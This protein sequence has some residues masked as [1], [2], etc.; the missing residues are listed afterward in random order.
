[1]VAFPPRFLHCRNCLRYCREFIYQWM[2]FSQERS[3][4][5][6]ARFH[7]E[8]AH[9]SLGSFR[10]QPSREHSPK[11][12]AGVCGH[13]KERR[14]LMEAAGNTEGSPSLFGLNMAYS[15]PLANG[16]KASVER[17]AVYGGQ[18]QGSRMK[19]EQR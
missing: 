6:L 2:L 3:M 1:M 7:V 16:L 10:H 12:I 17:K 11:N 18:G 19:L 13:E 8:A 4:M 9:L 15:E 14:A 5:S